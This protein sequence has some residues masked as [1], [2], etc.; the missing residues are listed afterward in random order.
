VHDTPDSYRLFAASK[1]AAS[2]HGTKRQTELAN[3]GWRFGVVRLDLAAACRT[4]SHQFYRPVIIAMAIVGVMQPSVYDVI[5]V[6]TVGYAFVSAVRPVCVGAPGVRRAARGVGVADLNHVFIDMIAMRVVQV[7]IVEVVDV[8]L[9]T[10]SRVSTART[11]LVSVIRMVILLIAEGHRYS[12]FL[13]SF[14]SVL[15]GQTCNVQCLM[16]AQL[17]REAGY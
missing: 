8:A 7:T 11:M 16:L 6:I 17:S 1:S 12:P 3:P 2:D 10:H 9:M 4:G 5:D 13:S 15:S 14:F